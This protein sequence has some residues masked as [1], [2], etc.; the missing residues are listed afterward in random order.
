MLQC[1]KKETAQSSDAYT[2][3][4]WQLA[5]R[6]HDVKY[7]SIFKEFCGNHS[8]SSSQKQLAQ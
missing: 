4:E 1:F 5:V 7:W 8:D 3:S 6:K 2:S